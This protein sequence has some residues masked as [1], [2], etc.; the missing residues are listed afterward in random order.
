MLLNEF[1]GFRLG[2]SFEEK[3]NFLV[4]KEVLENKYF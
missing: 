2:V 4:I 1:L 3:Y